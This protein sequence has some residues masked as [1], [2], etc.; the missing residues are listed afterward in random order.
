VKASAFSHA[1]SDL[2]QY[3]FHP[4]AAYRARR[5]SQNFG[6]RDGAGLAADSIEALLARKTSASGTVPAHTVPG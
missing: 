5:L 6:S 1:R 2:D 3:S 4:L